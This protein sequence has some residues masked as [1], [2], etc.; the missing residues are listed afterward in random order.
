MCFM[1]SGFNLFAAL[2]ILASAV[3]GET[4]RSFKVCADPRNLP[5]SNEQ[6]QGFEN[7]LAALIAK[8]LDMKLSYFWMPQREHFFSKTL[9]SGFCDAVMGV[10]AGFTEVDTTRP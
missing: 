7:R 4:V 6:G 2:L 1:F 8:D 9:N 10:P 3:S 5:F